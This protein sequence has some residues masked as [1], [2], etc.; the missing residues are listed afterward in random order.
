MTDKNKKNRYI[1]LIM[2]TLVQFCYGLAYVWSVFQP[3]ARERFS[4]DTSEANLPFGIF[5]GVFVAGNLTGGYLQKR[6]NTTFIIL[7]GSMVM[8]LGLLATAYVPAESGWLLNV[9]YGGISG[10]GCGCAYNTLLAAMQ[11]WFP[12]KRGMV[13]GII[14]CAVGLFGLI[15]NPTADYFL[16]NYGFTAAMTAVAAILFLICITCGWAVKAPAEN[17][18]EDYKPSN[19]QVTNRQ[20]T[21]REML[22]TK[23]YYIIAATFMLAVP[24]YMLMNPMLMSLGAERGLA[25]GTALL[26]VMLVSV[27]NA[28]GRLL[29]PWISDALGRRPILTALFLL[30]M[31]V[32]LLLTFASGYLFLVLVCCIAFAYGGFMGVYPAMSADYFGIKNAGMNYGVVM[33][34]Y[35]VSSIGCPYL[36]KA[37][38]KSPMGTALS[39]VIAAIASIIGLLL[40]FCL[41]KPN[42]LKAG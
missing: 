35:A 38:E 15:M 6:W 12:D 18:M 14:I 24:S 25:P 31:G 4:L 1:I 20:Y 9:T 30:N 33:L 27:M 2:G 19:V 28:A 21:I 37:V 11:K 13:T 22:G 5:L 32:I 10:F 39:F 26:G 23:Q 40:V 8:C 36:V 7:S 17:Y 3:Y 34:G 29:L 41:H 42:T 16:K